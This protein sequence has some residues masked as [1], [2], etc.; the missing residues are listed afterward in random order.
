MNSF[1]RF[2]YNSPHHVLWPLALA[3]FAVLCVLMAGCSKSAIISPAEYQHTATRSAP[4]APTATRVEVK[5]TTTTTTTTIT[6]PE[7]RQ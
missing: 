2:T 5:P 6:I 1:H 7:S 3:A 4:T